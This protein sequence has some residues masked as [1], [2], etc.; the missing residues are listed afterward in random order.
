MY[1]MGIVYKKKVVLHLLGKLTF[2]HFLNIVLHTVTN[3]INSYIR[4]EKNICVKLSRPA[5]MP[6]DILV[7]VSLSNIIVTIIDVTTGG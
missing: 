5:I 1:N 2:L 4:L 6:S 3:S 7:T